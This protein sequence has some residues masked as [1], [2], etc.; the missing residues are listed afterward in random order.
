[1][2]VYWF[3]FLLMIGTGITAH[4][5]YKVNI[6]AANTNFY[7]IMILTGTMAY[8]FEQLIEAIKKRG[9]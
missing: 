7:S 2:K 1:M 3:F 5:L 4:L 6:V 8:G 9:K